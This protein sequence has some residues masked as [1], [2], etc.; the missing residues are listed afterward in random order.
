[1]ERQTKIFNVKDRIFNTSMGLW[2][3]LIALNGIV[4]AAFSIIIALNPKG[5]KL[6]L[7]FFVI[8][9]SLLSIIFLVINFWQLRKEHMEK[10]K[11]MSLKKRKE[12]REHDDGDNEEANY[13]KIKKNIEKRFIK[14]LPTFCCMA[15]VFVFICF[16]LFS[17]LFKTTNSITVKQNNSTEQQNSR[18]SCSN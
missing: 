6:W 9:F 17:L 16:S 15:I 1:M 14:E 5:I 10:L 3:A 4:L 7:S 18:D 13:E 12:K 2:T 11:H 8:L